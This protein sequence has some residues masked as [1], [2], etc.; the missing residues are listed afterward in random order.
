V[1]PRLTV[2]TGRRLH[3]QLFGRH[4]L[5]LGVTCSEACTVRLVLRFHGRA[6]SAPVARALQPR[7]RRRVVL[8]LN[9]AGRALL[10][11]AGR[12]TLTLKARAVDRS[13]NVRL[14]N[15]LLRVSR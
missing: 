7:A 9:R 4:R 3:A 6:L 12:R 11:R 1:P 15:V 2:R 5:P 10:R 13:G 14:L 8:R